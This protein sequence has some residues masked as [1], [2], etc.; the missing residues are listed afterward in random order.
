MD[1]LTEAD[2]RVGLAQAERGLRAG[3]LVQRQRHQAPPGGVRGGQRVA[4]P[5]VVRPDLP[6]A[7]Q[8]LRLRGVLPVGGQDEMPC[9]CGRGLAAPVVGWARRREPGNRECP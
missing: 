7:Q 3:H 9:R 5:Q 6:L 8:D 1:T 2:R 4:D